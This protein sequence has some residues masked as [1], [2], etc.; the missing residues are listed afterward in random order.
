M[1]Q[2][3]TPFMF[4]QLAALR[5]E[6]IDRAFVLECHGRL[7]AADLAVELYRRLEEILESPANSVVPVGRKLE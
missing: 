3:D 5:T 6:L 2:G 4:D 7:D 1:N